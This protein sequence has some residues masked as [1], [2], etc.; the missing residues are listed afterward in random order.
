MWAVFEESKTA[1]P[2][3][4]IPLMATRRSVAHRARRGGARSVASSAEALV[5][6][7]SVRYG[8]QELD[9][10]ESAAPGG[11]EIDWVL[12][13]LPP[14]KVMPFPIRRLC[15]FRADQM[16]NF[17]KLLWLECP[18]ARPTLA[19]ARRQREW[20]VVGDLPAAAVQRADKG[21][22]S[23]SC[24]TRAV[25]PVSQAAVRGRVGCAS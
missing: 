12:I 11:T 10:S 14:N 20:P 19:S 6:S 2:D 7:L 8:E 17:D 23:G 18:S 16:S 9:R 15:D 1:S 5:T 24:A 21:W 4:S 13:W 3:T 25:C 22:R